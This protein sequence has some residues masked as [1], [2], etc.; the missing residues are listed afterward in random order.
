MMAP[1][2]P[3]NYA[4][5]GNLNTSIRDQDQDLDYRDL[6]R[7]AW[8]RRGIFFA[9]VGT[10]LLA[11]ALFALVRKPSYTGTARIELLPTGPRSDNAAGQI[12]STG[13]IS[14]AETLNT[15][16]KTQ[17]AELEDG[18]T[19]IAAVQALNWQ[20]MDPF[21][22]PEDLPSGNAL[23]NERGLPLDK[24]PLHRA[25]I[26]SLFGSALKAEQVK[27]TRLIDVSFTDRDP[28]K[29]AAAA[30]A[31]VKAELAQVAKRQSLT[32][33]E[34]T[35]ALESQLGPLKETVKENQER[36]NS[37]VEANNSELAGLMLTP[38]QGASKT[39]QSPSVDS[40]SIPMSQ[41]AAYNAEVSKLQI[42]AIAA[43]AIAT[44]TDNRDVNGDLALAGASITETPGL[45]SS[46][47]E[48][49]S[50]LKTLQTRYQ[51][52]SDIDQQLAESGAV[53]GENSQRM[54][55]LKARKEAVQA[56][57]NSELIAIQHRANSD[58]RLAN[59]AL[60]DMQ[61][62][63]RSQE[64]L[65]ATWS[66]KANE[67]MGLQ[68]QATT[69]QNLYQDIY[70]RS[71][72]T[73]IAAGQRIPRVGIIDL[74]SQPST[75]STHRSIVVADGLAVGV[76]LGILTI[77]AIATLNG[78][79]GSERAFRRITGM[80]VA[81]IVPKFAKGSGDEPY[82]LKAPN[83]VE[84][85]S[86]RFARTAISEGQEWSAAKVIAV[87]SP[88]LGDGKAVTCMN[89]AAAIAAQS[90]RVLIVSADVRH[91]SLP[92]SL[93]AGIPSDQGPGLVDVLLGRSTLENAVRPFA[94]VPGMYVLPAGSGPGAV[95]EL[96][97]SPAFVSF[98][99]RVRSDFDYV[100]IYTPPAASFSD[101]SV[102]ADV[103][104]GVIVVVRLSVTS[105][106]DFEQ[107]LSVLAPKV[108]LATAILNGVP[109]SRASK[110]NTS[111]RIG[112]A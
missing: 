101:A 99:E 63:V 24:A 57:L 36:L 106:E 85:E 11:S 52:K 72:E 37:Y 70:A 81:A 95:P 55:L 84:A 42:A 82:V 29:A 66:S 90:K 98:I 89:L 61:A 68:R 40:I 103:V 104:D 94:S 48:T 7:G 1:V 109:R 15:E 87:V 91:G 14:T 71:Q 41:L 108:R 17:L 79:I 18:G 74:A 20:N 27:G 60:A 4:T 44:T 13:D 77:L 50:G 49:G 67:F 2:S 58:L 3:E 73:A 51:E 96:L 19:I 105:R 80:S 22:I 107:A 69:S 35:S 65:V 25:L 23:A 76:L 21:A 43:K 34:L 59:L 6:I 92:R 39:D 110:A 31:V 9:I 88:S 78:T 102:V 16:M 86:Y 26:I 62:K 56:S 93:Q 10:A 30:N 38:S 33:Q 28:A 83:S 45:H 8:E 12:S 5:S 46:L 100:L 54:Q 112:V 75:P 64:Q 111:G 97:S 47:S 53:Y 32:A